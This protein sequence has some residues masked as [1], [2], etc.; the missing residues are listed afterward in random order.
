MCPGP[1]FTNFL[2][3]SFTEKEGQK[4]GQ[5]TNNTDRRMTAERCGHLCA[6]GIVNKLS[7]CWMGVFPVIPMIYIATYF[8]IV[9]SW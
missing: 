1:T 6:V 2:Q 4:Y 8:P 3:E 5:T 7:E 9:F